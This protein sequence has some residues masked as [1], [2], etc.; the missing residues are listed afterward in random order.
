MNKVQA[1]PIEF[2]EWLSEIAKNWETSKG[3][4]INNV[5]I[6][7]SMVKQFKGKFII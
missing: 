6:L 3:F 5:D 7:K 1:I 4:K 2:Q